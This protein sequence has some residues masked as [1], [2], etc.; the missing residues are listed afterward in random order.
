[1]LPWLGQTLIGTTD[2]DHDARDVVHVRP[3]EEDIAY[4]LDAVN[5]FFATELTPGRPRGRVRGRA[6][7]DLDRRP[8]QVRRHL[9][10]GRAVRDLERDDHDH[11]RQA[12]DLAADGQA[13]RRPDR[14]ARRQ[15]RPLHH[16]R[17]PARHGGRA[18]ATSPRPR[19]GR[20][21]SSPAATATSRTRCSRSG[22]AERIVPGRPDLLAEVVYAARREQARTVGDVLLRRTRLGLTA[23]R[24]LTG[25]VIG[26]VAG[27]LGRRARVGRSPPRTRD[28]A[29]SR[30]RPAKKASSRRRNFPALPAG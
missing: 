8:R 22:P 24:S 5:A 1:M 19:S 9:P 21:S 17:A 30:T 27:V 6:P 7:A 10:Q 14:R 11:R 29:P 18:G 16:A 2:T 3:A 28:R 20:A 12:H 26:R 25:A 23:A 15:R 4:L 13:D